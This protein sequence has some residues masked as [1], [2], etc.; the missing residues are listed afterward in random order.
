MSLW[1][2]F[3]RLTKKSTQKFCD[4][5]IPS[6]P[7]NASL[8]RYVIWL[9]SSSSEFNRV[10]WLKT[11]AGTFDNWLCAKISES[12]FFKPICHWKKL[13][14]EW[15]RLSEMKWKS[16]FSRWVPIKITAGI[17]FYAKTYAN[18]ISFWHRFDSTEWEIITCKIAF[19]DYTNFILLNFQFFEIIE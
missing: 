18:S 19:F 3:I 16:G 9:P 15:N 4:Q 2:Q 10:K 14:T 7:A 5:Y 17:F 1:R 12:K 13:E 8:S 6:K 11:L